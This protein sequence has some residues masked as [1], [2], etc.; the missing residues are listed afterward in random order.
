[1]ARTIAG[2]AAN[3]LPSIAEVIGSSPLLPTSYFFFPFPPRTHPI[4]RY[5]QLLPRRHAGSRERE[6]YVAVRP[7]WLHHRHVLDDGCERWKID[8]GVNYVDQNGK[9]VQLEADTVI[10]TRPLI[11]RL[12][13]Y[14][15]LQAKGYEVYAVGD[16][17]E[18]GMIVDA[19]AAAFRMAREI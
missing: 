11:P 18:P 12:D 16:C 15:A 10:P 1:M 13:L 9:G 4:P 14:D 3:R 17:V 8:T 5:Q 7:P 2:G 19:V 6:R